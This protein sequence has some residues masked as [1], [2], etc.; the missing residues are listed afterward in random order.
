[1]ARTSLD[2][3]L[4]LQASRTRQWQLD[5]ELGLLRELRQRLEDAQLRGRRDLPLWVLRDERLQGLL[6]EAERQVR[7]SGTPD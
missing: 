7:R 5:E 1:M 2:L 4:D 3:E 6:Q